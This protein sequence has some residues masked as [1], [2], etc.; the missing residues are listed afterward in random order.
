MVRL[1]ADVA[2]ESRPQLLQTTLGHLQPLEARHAEEKPHLAPQRL[3]R[4]DDLIVLR[5][6][7]T[8]Q[9]ETIS[10]AVAA[11]P[12]HHLELGG[13]PLLIGNAV[14]LL[15]VMAEQVRVPVQPE[16]A[17]G[18]AGAEGGDAGSAETGGC[19]LA[20]LAKLSQA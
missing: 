6:G 5:H 17:A 2:H 18:T 14:R 15:I 4:L 1:S 13:F 10:E 7:E 16:T 8:L 12:A 19:R 3:R 9:W 20:Q 11:A